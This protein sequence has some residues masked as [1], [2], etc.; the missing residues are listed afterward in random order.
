MR[1][2]VNEKFIERRAKLTRWASLAGLGVLFLGLLASFNQEYFILSLPALAIGLVLASISSYNANRYIKEPRPDQVLTKVLRGF[3]KNYHLFNYT[4]PVPYVLVTPSRIYAL[5]MKPHD[6]VIRRQGNRWRRD[7]RWRRVIFLFGEE[8]LGNPTR[9]AY[10]AAARLQGELNAVL[11]EEAPSVEP[12]IVFTHPNVQLEVAEKAAGEEGD[13]PVLAGSQLKR[14]IRA[15]PKGEAFKSDLR[16]RLTAFLQ[17]P[18][19]QQG[20]AE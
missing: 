16:Q 15:Q 13:V 10:S 9:D 14:Y 12:I 8:P 7:F 6:G 1:V 20:D 5:L 17:G 19:H 4:A 11:G 18:E 2:T 3:D